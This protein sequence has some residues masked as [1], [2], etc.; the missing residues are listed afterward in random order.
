MGNVQLRIA[1]F[2]KLNL[3]PLFDI[4][5]QRVGGLSVHSHSD[6]SITPSEFFY[7]LS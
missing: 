3:W 6:L 4:D 1:N 5:L 2:G 7:R